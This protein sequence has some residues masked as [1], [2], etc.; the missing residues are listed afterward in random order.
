M[1]HGIFLPCIVL[2]ET[3]AERLCG[4]FVPLV[5]GILDGVDGKLLVYTVTQYVTRLETSIVL[6]TGSPL[7]FL[8][9][10]LQISFGAYARWPTSRTP[11]LFD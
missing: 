7:A 6:D 9:L 4:L 3:P 11:H 8:Y 10:A 2:Y 1:L 5:S